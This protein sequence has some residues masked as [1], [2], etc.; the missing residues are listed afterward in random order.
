MNTN[1]L[2]SLSSA[3]LRLLRPLVRILL[4]K[5]VSYGTFA[6]WAKWVYVD[7]AMKEFT[8]K[9]KKQST[10]RI[11][12]LTGLS[13]KEVKRLQ[14]IAR[15]EDGGRDEKYNRAARVIAAWRRERDFLNADGEPSVLSITGPWATFSEIVR[16]Y[17]GDVPVRAILD[18]LLRIGAVEQLD[19]GKISLLAKAY[20]PEINEAD[21][22]HIL[23][24]DVAHLITTIDHNLKSES[25]KKSRLQRKVAYDNL[26]DEIL[27]AFRKLS[28]KRAQNLLEN[29]DKW[30]AEHDCDVN[31]SVQG[32]GRN[33][34]GLG[35]YYFEEPYSSEDQNDEK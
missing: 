4:R 24:T 9:D 32:S 31:P 33:I 28:T 2:K 25:T 5:G 30:L 21:K 16:R 34:A 11:S 10:S 26:P 35:I 23:G 3:V 29:L 1:H 22:L 12:V 27:P 14:E 20:I 17:S 13:R 19:N 15:P 8:I 18:E 6:D 7:I